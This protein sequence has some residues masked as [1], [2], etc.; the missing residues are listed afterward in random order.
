MFG[1]VTLLL[2]LANCCSSKARIC[3]PVMLDHD[4]VVAEGL[5]GEQLAEIDAVRRRPERGRRERWSGW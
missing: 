5:D 1:W 3:R 2:P 4:E